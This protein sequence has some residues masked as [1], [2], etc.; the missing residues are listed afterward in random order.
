MEPSPR[1]AQPTEIERAVAEARRELAELRHAATHGPLDVDTALALA[2]C[3]G[4]EHARR[5]L[6]A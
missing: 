2:F 1:P 5:L 4:V 6:G 3:A